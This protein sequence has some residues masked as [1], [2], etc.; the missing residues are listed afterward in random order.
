MTW[1]PNWSKVDGVELL[2]RG[3]KGLR[4]TGV[5]ALLTLGFAM[6]GCSQSEE[7]GEEAVVGTVE[8]KSL[9]ERLQVTLPDNLILHRHQSSIQATHPTGSIRY[10]MTFRAD[11]KL[12]RLIGSTKNI[13]TKHGWSVEAERH[14]AQAS[15]VRLRRNKK[16]GDAK[17]NRTIWFVPAA[18]NVVVCDGISVA[19]EAAK[20]GDPLKELCTSILMREDAGR[21]E[22]QTATK[23]PIGRSKKND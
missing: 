7:V 9:D 13:L 16:N 10:H 6:T 17:E 11:E 19:E 1:E 15:E 21:V 22:N 5:I 12:V 18:G 4:V 3:L 14:F 2:R 20:L 23:T 8:V